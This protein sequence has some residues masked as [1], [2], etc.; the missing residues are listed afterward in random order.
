MDECTAHVRLVSQR[1]HLT[2]ANSIGWNCGYYFRKTQ[3]AAS[4][5]CTI[6]GKAITQDCGGLSERNTIRH[7]PFLL[8]RRL[9]S[10]NYVPP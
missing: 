5:T 6:M 9:A 3:S 8:W 1:G 7:G 4:V 10:A 2:R